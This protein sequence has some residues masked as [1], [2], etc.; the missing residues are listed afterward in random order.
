M[1]CCVMGSPGC[2]IS[3]YYNII[4]YICLREG[5]LKNGSILPLLGGLNMSRG[6]MELG[7][8]ICRVIRG[9]GERKISVAD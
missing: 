1:M 2:D 9:V 8:V 6:T 3:V 7:R 5:L 4:L